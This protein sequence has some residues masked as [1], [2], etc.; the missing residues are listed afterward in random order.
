MEQTDDVGTNKV[1]D[2]VKKP[3]NNSKIQTASHS[4]KNKY[5]QTWFAQ[6]FC[7]YPHKIQ[8][9]LLLDHYLC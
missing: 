2:E 3:K 6:N 1:I 7:Q 4:C 5:F 8:S 9:H